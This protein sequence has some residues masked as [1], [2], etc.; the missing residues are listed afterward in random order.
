MNYI[1]NRFHA[2]QKNTICILSTLKNGRGVT[3]QGQFLWVNSFKAFFVYKNL[4]IFVHTWHKFIS[5]IC[6]AERHLVSPQPR[7]TYKL[8]SQYPFV[9]LTIVFV[10]GVAD[11]VALLTGVFTLGSGSDFLAAGLEFTHHMVVTWLDG[12]GETSLKENSTCI[13]HCYLPYNHIFFHLVLIGCVH[14]LL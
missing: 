13:I 7:I 6:T 5:P 2:W 9:V 1:T 8:N 12:V 4:L 14:E 11:I 3:C 10:L